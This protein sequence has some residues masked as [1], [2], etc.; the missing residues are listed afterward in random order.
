MN[1]NI[2][3]GVLQRGRL[4]PND[5]LFAPIHTLDKFPYK[6]VSDDHKEDVADA[7]FNSGKFWERDWHL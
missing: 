1:E 4:A 7:F 2:H 5:K 6:F 3:E